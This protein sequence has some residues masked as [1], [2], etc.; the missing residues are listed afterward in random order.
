MLLRN[1]FKFWNWTSSG[2]R[3]RPRLCVENLEDRCLLSFSAA[4]NYPVGLNPNAVVTGDFNGDGRLDLAVANF[5]S[6]TV[7]ILLGNANGTFQ[8]AQN[9]ATGYGPKSLAMGDFNGDGKLDIVT[10]NAVYASMAVSVLLG[11]GNGTFQAPIYAV[12]LDPIGQGLIPMSAAVGDF[13]G[14]GKLD[15]VVASLVPGDLQSYPGAIVD[16]VLLGHGDGSFGAQNWS[17]VIGEQQTFNAAV[18]VGDFNGDGK[19]DLATAFHALFGSGVAVALGTG[20]GTFSAP[21]SYTV[22]YSP[23]SVA[24]GDVNGD[25]KLDLVTGNTNDVS[26]L[27]GNGTGSFGA[28]QY[29]AASSGIASVALADFNGDG[30]LDIVGANGGGVSMLFGTGTGSFWPPVN[31]AAA[32]NPVGVVVGDFNGDGD[33]D[34]AWAGYSANTVSVALNTNDWSGPAFIDVSGVPSTST[35]GVA[36]TFTATIRDSFGNIDTGYRRTMQFR[37]TDAQAF[38]PGPYTFTAAD[39]GTHTFSATLKTAGTQLLTVTDTTS[40]TLTNQTRVIVNPA[41][42]STFSVTGFP[43]STTAG[44]GGYLVITALDPYGNIDTGYA[45]MVHFSSS[46]AQAVLPVDSLLD[47]GQGGESGEFYAILKTAGTQSLTATDTTNAGLTGTQGGITVYPPVKSLAVA[48]FSSPITAGVAGSVTVTARDANGNVATWYTGTIAFS[49][50]DGKA[51]L[52]ANY[53]F[54]AADAGV[55]TFIATLKTAGTQS[56]TVKDTVTGTPIATEGGITVNPAAA[57]QFVIGAPSSVS[58]GL[59]FSLTVTVEDAYGNVVTGYTGTIHLSS[60]DPRATLP[61]N[62]TF[63][64]SDKGVHTFTGLVL[65][66]KGRQTVTITDTLNSS[67]TK[68]VI[69]NVL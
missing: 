18:A 34:I 32:S 62:Y 38:L 50:S 65:R 30:K 8:P 69:E 66:K 44:A 36:D 2:R 40:S 16:N 22:G 43:S 15:L 51:S 7:S 42:A 60:S 35:A 27:L 4:V 56:I 23:N 67:L 12:L 17:G 19:L 45:G 13:N 37:S 59:S 11:N 39:A 47:F 10:A 46:D 14:D 63:T 64:A 55:H 25:G 28:A 52:P 9:F 48:G 33:P 24:V 49:S 29:Y 61:A 5:S 68:G 54:T 58:A 1:I 6:N 31:V 41:S 21:S 3:P 53:T 20:T 57:S 26:V